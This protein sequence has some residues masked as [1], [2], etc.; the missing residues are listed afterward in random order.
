MHFSNS[1]SGYF[2]PCTF[3]APE[4][5]PHM[6]HLTL[7]YTTNLAGFDPRAALNSLNIAL[8]ESSQFEGPDIKSRAIASDCFQIGVGEVDVAFV[9]VNLSLLSGRTPQI[10]KDLSSRLLQALQ[11]LVASS[12]PIS[13]LEI[14][15]TV[16]VSDLDRDCYAKGS[17]RI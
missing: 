9:H 15:I 17:P 11:N 4:K 7:E 5:L 1:T 12:S 8:V 3:R 13:T 16:D 10:K 14:Q 6:P 2:A